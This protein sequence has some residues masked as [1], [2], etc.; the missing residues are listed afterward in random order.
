MTA[1]VSLACL[2]V[3][4]HLYSVADKREKEAIAKRLESYGEGE[5][6]RNY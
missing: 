2:V 4:V 5:V 6:I 3:A 1:F